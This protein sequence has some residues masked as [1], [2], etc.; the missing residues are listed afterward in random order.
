[1]R[2]DRRNDWLAFGMELFTQPFAFENLTVRMRHFAD[3]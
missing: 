1:V 3:I 2:L